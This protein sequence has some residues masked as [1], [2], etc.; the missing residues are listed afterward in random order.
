MKVNP[1]AEGSSMIMMKK[2]PED[3]YVTSLVFEPELGENEP[4]V[5][6]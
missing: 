5:I 1:F 2:K 3:I 4:Q 6:Q